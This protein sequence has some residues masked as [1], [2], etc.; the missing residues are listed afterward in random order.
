MY[1]RCQF[2]QHSMKI[3]YACRSQK[4]KRCLWL[5]L[6]EFLCFWAMGAKKSASKCVGEIDTRCWFHQ[7]FTISFYKCRS[8]KC[9]KKLTTWLTFLMLF[10][11]TRPKAARKML[12][13]LTTGKWSQSKPDFPS[14]VL[15]PKF[16]SSIWL[17]LS[18]RLVHYLLSLQ[19]PT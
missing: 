3:F 2:H 9:K 18:S 12:M 10:G 11:S 15:L 7:H 8:Q 17:Q 4:R 5:S 16:H 14:R 1:I 13:K 19:S 6:S